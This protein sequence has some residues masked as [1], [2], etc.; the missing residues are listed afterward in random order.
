MPI[1]GSFKILPLVLYLPLYLRIN[2]KKWL[3]GNSVIL[4]AFLDMLSTSKKAFIMTLFPN[5]H[6]YS[7]HFREKSKIL[8][9]FVLIF[10][11]DV[12][13]T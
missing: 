10:P 11:L 9:K 1:Y 4:K 7:N 3:F 13:P 2:M 8:K 12:F 6:F 5:N